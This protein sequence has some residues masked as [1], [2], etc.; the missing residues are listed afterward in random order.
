MLQSA[1]RR[2]ENVRIL[3]PVLERV[4]ARQRH[5]E[6]SLVPGNEARLS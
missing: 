5:E 3:L 4:H 1:C 2:P 6:W